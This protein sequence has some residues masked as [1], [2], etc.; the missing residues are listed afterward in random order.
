MANK[1][2]TMDP[3]NMYAHYILARNEND[4]DDDKIAK[5]KVV[6]EK[7]PEFVRVKNDIGNCYSKAKM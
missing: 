2:L 1:I 3:E 7:F 6:A 5:L 4:A